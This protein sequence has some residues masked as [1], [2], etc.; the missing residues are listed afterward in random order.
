MLEMLPRAYRSSFTLLRNPQARPI[1]RRL[2]TSQKRNSSQWTDS[3]RNQPS[4]AGVSNHAASD[5]ILNQQAPS[6]Q[7][8]P[9]RRR[10]VFSGIQPTGVPHLGNYIGALRQWKNYHEESS[11]PKVT[12]QYAPEQY[13]SIVDLHALTASMP[14][15][16]RKQLRKE[17]YASLLAIGLKNTGTTSV[18]FQ[19]DVGQTVSGMAGLLKLGRFP[20][21]AS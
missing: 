18:F 12:A 14:R 7:I 17:S 9:D 15:E 5:I 13:F 19:S 21:I 2:C 6:P 1:P 8:L 10:T 4:A 20:I 16:E 3:T 11:N